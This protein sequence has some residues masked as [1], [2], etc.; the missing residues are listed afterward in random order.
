MSAPQRVLVTGATG[1]VGRA[2]IREAIAAGF[3][4][5]AATRGVIAENQRIDGADYVSIGEIHATTDWCPALNGADFVIH[6]AGA[7]HVASHEQLQIVNVQGSERLAKQAVEVGVRRWVFVS[8]LGVHG[9]YSAGH[10]IRADDPL[11][12]HDAYTESKVAAEE[13]IRN[14]L[15]SSATEWVIVRP[16]LIYG[17]EATGTVGRMAQLLR[18]RVPLPIASIRNRRSA[19]GVRNLADFLIH[20]L[21]AKQAAGAAWVVA[22]ERDYSSLE[23][24]EIVARQHGYPCR[25]FACPEA[26]L[27]GLGYALHRERELNQLTQSLFIDRSAVGE[28]LLWSAPFIADQQWM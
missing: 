26:W 1:F 23:L 27:R 2:V 28:R 4:V 24:F 12:P 11:C 13:R 16:P 10:A 25:A 18:W 9:A 8:S 17:A 20:S 5:T 15:K 3:R 14:V 19:I 7:T 6:T 22:D 21:R